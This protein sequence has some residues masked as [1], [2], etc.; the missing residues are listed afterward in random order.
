MLFFEIYFEAEIYHSCL[1]VQEVL[2]LHK[3]NKNYQDYCGLNQVLLLSFG[4]TY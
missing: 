4:R 1:G 3:E 2:F